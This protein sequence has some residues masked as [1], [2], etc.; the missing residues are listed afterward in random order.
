M[1]DKKNRTLPVCFAIAFALGT[2]GFLLAVYYTE[3]AIGSPSSTSALVFVFLLPYAVISGLVGAVIGYLISKVY[4]FCGFKPL[5]KLISIG[6]LFLISSAIVCTATFSGFIITKFLINHT[7][8]RVIFTNGII[9]QKAGNSNPLINKESLLLNDESPLATLIWNNK[10][11]S[12]T[13]SDRSIKIK[14]PDR[15]LIA[16]ESLWSYEYITEVQAIEGKLFPEQEDYLAIL[17]DLRATSHRAML[18][19][20]SPKAELVYQEMLESYG[21]IKLFTE[22]DPNSNL[23]IIHVKHHRSDYVFL[24]LGRTD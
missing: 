20:Y 3:M 19:I 23:E 7:R 6:L 9:C 10:K 12:I 15:N 5:S 1:S 14:R 8:P 18:Y 16:K 21:H 22:K 4:S 13:F 17:A 24:P 11:I 2:S